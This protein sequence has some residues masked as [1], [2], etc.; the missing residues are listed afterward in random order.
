[1]ANRKVAADT[2]TGVCTISVGMSQIVLVVAGL[3][4]FVS[5]SVV[6]PMKEVVA[7]VA[8]GVV[9]EEEEGAPTHLLLCKLLL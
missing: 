7:V 8:V 5:S 3:V 2:D 9:G 4:V 6:A 1:M